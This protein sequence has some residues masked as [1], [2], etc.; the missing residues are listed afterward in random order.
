MYPQGK[1]RLLY[2]CFPMSLLVEAA[3]GKASNGRQRILDLQATEIH[4]RSAIFLGTK[5]EVEAVEAYYKKMD[6]GEL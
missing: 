2:E 4:A 1:L 3:G 5:E 6:A